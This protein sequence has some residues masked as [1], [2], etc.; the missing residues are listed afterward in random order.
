MTSILTALSVL[1]VLV[2]A[3]MLIVSA[4]ELLPVLRTRW[5]PRNDDER[6]PV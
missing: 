4:I 6:R 2:F 1:S 3:V 5:H